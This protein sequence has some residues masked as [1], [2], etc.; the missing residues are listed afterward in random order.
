MSLDNLLQN[1]LLYLFDNFSSVTGYN[2]SEFVINETPS[3]T[4][5]NQPFMQ[6]YA[7]GQSGDESVYKYLY[8]P[9]LEFGFRFH[10][11]LAKIKYIDRKDPWITIIFKTGEKNPL[12]NVLSHKYNH[13]E[14]SPD[15]FYKVNC[16]RGTIPINVVFISNSID[17][18]YSF[19]GKLNFWFDRTVGFEYNQA[20]QYSNSF[21]KNY[22]LSAE[23]V[24]IVQKDL[25]KLDNERRGSLATAGYSFDMIYWELDLPEQGHILKTI[26]L[27]IKVVDN[28]TDLNIAHVFSESIT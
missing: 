5:H 26:D 14:V 18:L 28:L 4:F 13:M 17:Y 9:S 23:A 16:R 24:N 20:I 15:K 8:D 10:Q 19:L 25:T 11:R 3:T 27:K 2:F 21:V 7:D 6:Q 1:P 12:T 22:S